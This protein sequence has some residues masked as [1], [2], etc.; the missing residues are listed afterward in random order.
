MYLLFSAF[1]D[2]EVIVETVEM[3]R[4]VGLET[5]HVKQGLPLTREKR[6]WEEGKS[7][8]TPK[9]NNLVHTVLD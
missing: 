8:V 7:R 1:E 6:R 5:E 9:V 4:A 2:N 3:D